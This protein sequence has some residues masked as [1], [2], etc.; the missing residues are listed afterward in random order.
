VNQPATVATF[1][2]PLCYASALVEL[3]FQGQQKDVFL[4]L[5]STSTISG[6]V[7]NWDRQT[8][9]FGALVDLDGGAANLGNFPTAADGSFTIS[10]VAADSAIRCRA[11]RLIE[12]ND[13]SSYAGRGPLPRHDIAFA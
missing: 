11:H 5:T 7:L 3:E 2:N 6:R 12:S 8:P 1:E 13:R 4:T 9:I 10:G